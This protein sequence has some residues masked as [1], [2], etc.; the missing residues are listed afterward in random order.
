ML[1]PSKCP[2]AADKAKVRSASEPSPAHQK[3][4]TDTI[5]RWDIIQKCASFLHGFF[6]SNVG[7]FRSSSVDAPPVETVASSETL[8][9]DAD[10]QGMTSE[11]I[12]EKVE[13]ALTP[14]VAQPSHTSPDLSFASEVT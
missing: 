9:E 7:V 10:I 11:V 2:G 8:P 4:E 5:L 6:T 13:E 12:E 14:A 1:I 3:Q